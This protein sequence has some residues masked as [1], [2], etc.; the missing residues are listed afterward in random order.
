MIPIFICMTIVSNVSL[1]EIGEG[2]T[3]SSHRLQTIVGDLHDYLHHHYTDSYGTHDLELAAGDMHHALHEWSDGNITEA[4]VVAEQ[5][6]LK[7]AWLNY[8]Q[9]I[10]PAGILNNGDMELEELYQNLKSTYKELRFLLRKAD[11]GK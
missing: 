1:A 6:N 11:G 4:D 8:I 9:S 10:T 7:V 5:E 2:A 3:S